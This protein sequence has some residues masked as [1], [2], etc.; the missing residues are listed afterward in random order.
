MKPISNEYNLLLFD[1]LFLLKLPLNILD[2][3]KYI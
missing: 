3:I 1:S 2:G